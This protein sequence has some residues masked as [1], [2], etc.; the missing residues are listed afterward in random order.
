MELT[1]KNI[2]NWYK[3]KAYKFRVRP[4]EINLLGIRANY[5]AT[6]AWDD[7]LVITYINDNNEE[8]VVIFKN[9]TTDPGYYFLKTKLL[10][11]KGCAFLKE[12]NY[13]NM[14]T[15]GLH[16]GKYKALKQY[17]NITVYRDAD[18]DD[19]LEFGNEESGYFGINLHHGFNSAVI[20]NNS[21]GCQVLKSPKDL[22]VVVAL[23][24]KHETLYGAGI[25]YTLT[26]NI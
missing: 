15:V 6:N 10:N 1:Y 9:F 17:S 13:K 4:N 7:T 26:S 16:L 18:K 14:F 25:D 12:G 8:K 11:P 3:G 20:F 2:E 22:D 19:N 24:E 23:A 21:A 5:V